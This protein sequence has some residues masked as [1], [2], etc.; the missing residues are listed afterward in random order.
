MEALVRTFSGDEGDNNEQEQAKKQQEESIIG[1]L[2]RTFSGDAGDNNE[3]EKKQQQESLLETFKRAF[4]H[5]DLNKLNAEAPPK[6]VHSG[7]VE[8][9]KEDDNGY[10]VDNPEHVAVQDEAEVV[11]VVEQQNHEDEEERLK[12]EGDESMFQITNLAQAVAAADAKGKGKNNFEDCSAA[13]NSSVSFGSSQVREYERVIDSTAIYMGLSLGWEYNVKPA[14][15]IGEKTKNKTSKYSAIRE[16]GEARMKR[17]NGSDRY[18]MLLKY[19]YKQKELKKATREAAQFYKNRQR[20]AARVL[21]T[22][23][24]RDKKTSKPK[25][26]PLRSMFK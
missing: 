21:V 24:E 6:R 12:E 9:K 15:L 14:A 20:E 2:V 10:P 23:E 11:R 4:S 7:G 19:G 18:G 22:A 17:T 13:S 1:A 16:G 5:P 26:R 8:E 3:Q 25:S